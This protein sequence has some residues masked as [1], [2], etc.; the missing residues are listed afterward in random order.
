MTRE[1]EFNILHLTD[2]HGNESLIEK[3]REEILGADLILLSGDITHFGKENE[4]K[5]IL[6]KIQ[7][8]NN[9]VY[10][11]SGNCDYPEVEEY[12][13]KANITLHR[14][15]KHFAG[16]NLT[17]LSGSL[18]CP[19]KTPLEYSETEAD[20]WLS[21]IRKL[22]IPQIPLILLSHQP[23]FNTK[24]DDVG[25]NRHVGSKAVRNFIE[26]VN[27]VLCLTGHIHEGIGIDSIGCCKIVNPGPSRVGRYATIAISNQSDRQIVI[28]VKQFTAQ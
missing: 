24:N 11:V 17:G 8:Q 6:K 14:K 12:L 16:Y 9:N 1:K 3:I 7:N 25:H 20:D 27:P 5:N 18:P 26:D 2:L 10:A 19:G 28:N 15:I 4:A 21:E 23:P 22:L 13:R